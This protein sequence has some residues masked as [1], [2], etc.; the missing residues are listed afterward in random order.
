MKDYDFC[1]DE[2]QW[3][4]VHTVIKTKWDN[5]VDRDA[6]IAQHVVHGDTKPNEGEQEHPDSGL[7]NH[8]KTQEE[9]DIDENPVPID[10]VES[11]EPP[12]EPQEYG[13]E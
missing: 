11:P 9:I 8:D 7:Y 3:L 13:G 4:I 1:G 5:E 12:T 10:G 6:H 2:E